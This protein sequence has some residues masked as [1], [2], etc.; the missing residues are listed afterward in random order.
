MGS[1]ALQMDSLSTELSGKPVCSMEHNFLDVSVSCN[2]KE[3]FKCQISLENSRLN[4]LNG[5]HYCKTSKKLKCVCGND[6]S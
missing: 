5:F 1:P 6:K 3:K 4:N 2:Q